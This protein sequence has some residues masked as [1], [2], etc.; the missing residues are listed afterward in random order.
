MRILNEQAV[1]AIER[2]GGPRALAGKLLGSK[3]NS[4]D[5]LKMQ[6]RISKWR[7]NG[8]PAKWVLAVEAASGVS[9]HR[10]APLVFPREQVSA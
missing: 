10:L 4:A 9:R 8:V 2:A 5:L 7:Y 3:A 6:S 1:K